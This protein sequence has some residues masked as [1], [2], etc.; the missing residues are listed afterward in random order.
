MFGLIPVRRAERNPARVVERPFG[1]IR[2]ELATLFE[3]FFGEAP[4]LELPWEE[5][6]DEMKMENKEKEVLLKIAVPGFDPAE[7]KV[8]ITGNLLMIRAEHKEKEEKEKKERVVASMV[9]SIVLPVGIEPEKVEAV[10]KNGLLEMVLP[11]KA[12]AVTRSIEVKT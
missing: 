9:R 7:I 4:L 3:R 1:M 5:L 8:E 12:E 2:P 6:D 11:K 10:C